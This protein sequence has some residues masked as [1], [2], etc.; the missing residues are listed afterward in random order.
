MQLNLELFDQNEAPRK[1][2]ADLGRPRGG[3]THRR[4]RGVGAPDRAH[5]PGPASDERQRLDNRIRITS[6]HLSRQAI[7]S[8]FRRIQRCTGRE[9]PGSR[10][11]ET[12]SAFDGGARDLGWP[13][14][15]IIVI[16]G[17]LRPFGVGL[18]G[19]FG[20]CPPF[21][22]RSRARARR[23]R[24]APRS[25]TA[26][27]QRRRDRIASSISQAATEHTDRQHPTAFTIRPSSMIASLSV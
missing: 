4:D 8:I 13:D 24:A 6:N 23:P 20:L 26:H 11:I 19:A 27:P 7:H 2:S 3:H 16:D 22:S 18:D 25:L 12:G 15:R 5:A 1:T 21:T 10:R 14:E 9:Q 17:A